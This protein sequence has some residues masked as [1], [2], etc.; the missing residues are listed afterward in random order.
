[1]IALLLSSVLGLA[2]QDMPHTM[3]HGVHGDM[4]GE[5]ASSTTYGDVR[6]VDAEART[7]L[8]RHGDMPELG[9]PGMVMEFRV[10]E[11]VDIAL[12]EPGAA[13]QITVIAGEHGLEVIAAQPEEG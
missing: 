11:A 9:M 6:T 4:A 12:F 3:D 10:A 13:L 1:M 8:I 2:G 7:A 5:Q